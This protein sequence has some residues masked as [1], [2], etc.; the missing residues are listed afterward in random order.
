MCPSVGFPNPVEVE[1]YLPNSKLQ[2]SEKTFQRMFLSILCKLTYNHF[3]LSTHNLL[4]VELSLLTNSFLRKYSIVNISPLLLIRQKISDM[5]LLCKIF[6]SI[7]R[8]VSPCSV[9]ICKYVVYPISSSVFLDLIK[10]IFIVTMHV[11]VFCNFFLIY[12]LP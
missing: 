12:I 4:N 1:Q 6:L 5:F 11:F 9:G 10:L 2:F 7:L 8:L 3:L